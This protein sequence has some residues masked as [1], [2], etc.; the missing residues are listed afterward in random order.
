[1]MCPSTL[2]ATHRRTKIVATWGPAIAPE[3]VLRRVLRAGVDVFRLNFSHA[4]HAEL[5]EA[6]PLIRRVATEEG[7]IVALL[8]DVQGPR[9]RTGVLGNG[10]VA[11]VD[12]ASVTIATG[13]QPTEPGRITIAYPR[14]ADDLRPG[15]RVLIADGTIVLEVTVVDGDISARVVKGG[16]LGEHKGVN[17][18][19][20]SV[21]M[22][23]LTEKDRRD[24]E[25]GVRLGVDFVALS[26][27]RR[28]EDL[29]D[30]RRLVSSLGSNTPIIAKIESPEAIANLDDRWRIA[31]EAANEASHD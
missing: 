8:Q 5:E 12:G 3:P 13:D 27:V 23:A 2:M 6:V 14:L 31:I 9:L 22:G 19:D 15:H 16:S 1:M 17:L 7:R 26:F 4:T 20:T 11:L 25:F 18:P 10:P 30:C 21:S 29:L 28:R 24:L